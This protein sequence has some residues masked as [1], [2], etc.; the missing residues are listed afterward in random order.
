MK[1]LI[2]LL[3]A[4]AI[5][6]AA[7]G[8]SPAGPILAQAPNCSAPFL[9]DVTF[10]GGARWEMC[11][12]HRASEGIVLYDVYFT[13]PGAT[14]RPVFGQAGLAQI[15]VPYDDNGARF[16]D[17][18][19]YGLGNSNMNDL[20]PAECPGG[21]LLQYNGKDVLCQMVE[22][23]SYYY[24]Y[25]TTK[26]LAGELTLFSVSHIGEYNYV[27]R[28]SFGEDGHIGAEIGAT[29][30]LQRFGNNA[31][32]G[33]PVR[34]G[35]NPYAVSHMHNL[36]WRLDFDVGGKE[37]DLAEEF[38]LL[39]TPDT[40]RRTIVKTELVTEAARPVSPTA[41]R[42]WRVR[43]KVIVNAD[44]RAIS[45]EIEPVSSA[46]Y[47]GPSN[48]PW[49]QNDFYVTIYKACEKWVSHN[50]T[51]GGCGGDVTAFVNGESVDGK[52]V[53]VWYGVDFHHTPRD[54]DEPNMPIDWHGFHIKPRD[55]IAT[56]PVVA[57][58]TAPGTASPTSTATSTPSPTATTTS[59]ATATPTPTDTPV[60]LPTACARGDANCDGAVDAGDLTCVVVMI[61]NGP[62][63]CPVP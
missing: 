1:R 58:P 54:E 5:A 34:T 63:A 20:T 28:W 13:S 23:H 27:P 61:F 12:E 51:T 9:I 55:W 48:E 37:D 43:D 39:P 56:S 30:R 19:D 40:A 14:R 41:M 45:Y 10:G 26:A 25:Y 6:L 8:A 15:H 3:I 11:W 21:T 53:V 44:G 18:S 57:S 50:P 36:Y 32:Y 52:D 47:R 46:T 62:D 24:K 7:A 4:V 29:G 22:N 60:P 2:L 35:S 33:W 59:T 49:T 42:F 16:H 38:D 17:L 31:S